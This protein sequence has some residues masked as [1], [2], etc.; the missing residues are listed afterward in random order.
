MKEIQ[1]NIKKFINSNRVASIC[2]ND[3][4]GKPYCI[5][6]FFVYNEENSVLIFKSSFGS[7]HDKLV[8]TTAAVAGTILPEKFDV[9]KIRGIQFTGQILEGNNPNVLA[10]TSQYYKK[11]PTG[12]VMPGYIWA[13]KLNYIK[14]TDN[15]L[16]FGNKSIWR[17]EAPVL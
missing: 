7:G 16:G 4:E 17:H 6:C 13:V 12:L 9:L 8:Q 11:Y 3:G 10:F 1:E 14:F 15:T 2:F 5:S